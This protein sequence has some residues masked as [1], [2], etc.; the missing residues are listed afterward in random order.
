MPNREQTWDSPIL[1]LILSRNW[2]QSSQNSLGLSSTENMNHREMFGVN[3]WSSAAHNSRNTKCKSNYVNNNNYVNR[4]NGKRHRVVK[5]KLVLCP[6]A[7]WALKTQIYVQKV[8]EAKIALQLED[9]LVL[10]SLGFGS[11][12]RFSCLFVAY[13]SFRMCLTSQM[14]SWEQIL[15]MNCL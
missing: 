2:I 12:L 10:C 3:L 15:V 4:V 14:N 6:K 1:R 5:F 13:C 8:M 7:S 9:V 11:F